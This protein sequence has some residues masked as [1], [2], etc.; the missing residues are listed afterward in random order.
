MMYLYVR[1]NYQCF[2][3]YSVPDQIIRQQ[4]KNGHIHLYSVPFTYNLEIFLTS[5]YTE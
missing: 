5:I 2:T 4:R 1:M 3:S